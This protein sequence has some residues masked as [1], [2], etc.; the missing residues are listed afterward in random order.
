M[1]QFTIGKDIDSWCGKCKLMLAHTIETVVD[2]KVK[3]AHC[4]TCNA[5]HAYKAYP[6]GESPRR[7][8]T[9]R[10]SSKSNEPPVPA[11]YET[12]LKRHDAAKA[13]PYVGATAYGAGQLLRHTH[14]GLGIITAR[15]GNKID[16]L[17]PDKAR[18]LVHAG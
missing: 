16:V 9:T 3:R 15:R 4:N 17:F 14:F 7:A 11:D 12:L 8:S 5:Q 2:G 13:R 10:R 18:T 6:P 1:T